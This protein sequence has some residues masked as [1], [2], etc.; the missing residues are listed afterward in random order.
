M[1]FLLK[2]W[3]DAN[4]GHQCYIHTISRKWNEVQSADDLKERIG[5]DS[6]DD[7]YYVGITGRNWLLRLDEHFGE[8]RR[9][10]RRKFYRV[11]RES[12]GMTD[13][14]YISTL[15]DINMTYEDAMNW[16]ELYVD[17]VAYGPNGLNMIPGGFKGQRLLHKLRLIDRIDISLEDRDKAIAEYGRKNPMK[18]IPNP[19]IAELS[20]DEDSLLTTSKLNKR[21]YR[22]TKS[23]GLG[24]DPNGALRN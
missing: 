8:M 11:W 4:N 3:G 5:V 22:P 14:H 21:P 24:I 16:E 2:G 15:M 13:V 9:D 7:Y 12:L 1:Q 23:E 6:D 20:K 17:K 19:F 18:G 10:N